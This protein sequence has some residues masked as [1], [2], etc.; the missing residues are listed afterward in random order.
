M[1]FYLRKSVKVGP[2]RF[3]LSGSGVGV[4]AGVRGLR[5]GTGPRGNYVHMGS[6]GIYYRAT[7]PARHDRVERRSPAEPEV[8]IDAHE[9]LEEIES[10]EVSEIVDSSS[11]ELLMELD[12][13]RK[14]SRLFPATVVLA[15][16]ALLPGLALHWPWWLLLSLL[17]GSVVVCFLVYRRDLLAKTVVLLY[18][19]DPEMEAAYGDLHEAATQLASCSKVWHIEAHGRVRERKYHAGADTVVRRTPTFI[20]KAQPPF[21]KT[22]IETVAL[23]VGRQTLYLFPDRLLVFEPNGV[24]AVGYQYLDIVCQSSQFVEDGAVP[25]DAKIIDRTWRYVNK[26]G[27]PDRRF[28]D[29]P[30]IPVCLYDEI[31]LQSATGLNERI[32]LSRAGVAD[33]FSS[34]VEKLAGRLDAAGL[35]NSNQ[36]QGG[37][38]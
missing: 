14:K 10:A 12:Q 22:N 17:L 7:I 26:K 11:E 13:K 20:R 2:L 32:Q 1:G 33:Q 3:N 9:P 35:S 34:A 30:Q 5:F 28:N 4:S 25:S 29:N 16:V 21:L 19:L 38:P 24:G 15:V 37:V 6:H 31:S 8:P 23:G 18:E 27:G 36:S